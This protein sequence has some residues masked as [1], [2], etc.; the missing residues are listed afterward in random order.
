MP[1]YQQKHLELHQKSQNCRSTYLS[2]DITK[3]DNAVAIVEILVQ[4]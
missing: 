2:K 1:E 4:E 3:I